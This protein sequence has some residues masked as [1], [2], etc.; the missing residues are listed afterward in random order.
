MAHL[1]YLNS[2]EINLSD[3]SNLSDVSIYPLSHPLSHP[4]SRIRSLASALSH[5]LSRIRSL[6]SALSHPLSFVMD[7]HLSIYLSH[8]LD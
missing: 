2:Y 6:A 1:I 3:L 7:R 4:L 8:V 5:L